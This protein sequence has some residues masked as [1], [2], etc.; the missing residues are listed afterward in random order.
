VTLR[1]F[2]GFSY[3]RASGAGA[4]I[5]FGFFNVSLYI[6]LRDYFIPIG[7]VYFDGDLLNNLGSGCSNELN[8]VF[9][10]M[11]IK[12]FGGWILFC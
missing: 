9:F 8:A 1:S 5:T 7:Y 4:R 2:F 6:L 3:K 11:I 10:G 12:L